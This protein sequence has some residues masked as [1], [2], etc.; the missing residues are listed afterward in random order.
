MSQERDR[1]LKGLTFREFAAVLMLLQPLQNRTKVVNMLISLFYLASSTEDELHV[2]M[3]CPADEP[4]RRAVKCSSAW[5]LEMCHNTT[6][7]AGNTT[8]GRV[9]QPASQCAS[10][11]ITRRVKYRVR[12]IHPVIISIWPSPSSLHISLVTK[13]AERKKSIF[14]FFHKTAYPTHSPLAVRKS[15]ADIVRT[16]RATRR[17]ESLCAQTTTDTMQK[18]IHLQLHLAGTRG[19][20]KETP[21]SPT[22]P[23]GHRAHQSRTKAATI[24]IGL[25]GTQSFSKSSCSCSTSQHHHAA[26][27]THEAK[28]GRKSSPSSRR[29]EE[30]E[31]RGSQERNAAAEAHSTAQHNTSRGVRTRRRICRPSSPRTRQPP[32][33]QYSPGVSS[34]LISP[35]HASDARHH[36]QCIQPISGSATRH[37]RHTYAMQLQ[38]PRVERRGR[39]GGGRRS[40]YDSLTSKA[41]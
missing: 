26:E 21:P 40:P 30:S 33:F 39:A 34:S 32:L 9:G 31:P 37:V 22:S 17:E 12:G 27:L 24:T 13:E 18:H 19:P 10:D 6:V 16:P 20:T 29:G 11:H 5:E 38:P 2:L 14:A 41:T 4:L 1:A 35:L 36:D 8:M 7:T 28:E 15:A 23:P 3:E 25:Q